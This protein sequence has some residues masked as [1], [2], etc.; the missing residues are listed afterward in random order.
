MVRPID[1]QDNLSKISYVE[2]IQQAQQSGEQA[3]HEQFVKNLNRTAEKKIKK[4]QDSKEAEKTR[5]RRKRER[6]KKKKKKII[7][8]TKLDQP[9][10]TEDVRKNLEFHHHV[11]IIV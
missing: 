11:D 8:V 10:E 9:I 4:A 6:K 5:E 2:K 3:G 1:I 7:T